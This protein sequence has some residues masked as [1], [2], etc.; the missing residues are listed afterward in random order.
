MRSL[1]LNN[2]ATTRKR[3]VVGFGFVVIW[4][5]AFRDTLAGVV[6]LARNDVGHSHILAIPV[7][8]AFFIYSDRVRIFG[9]G[10]SGEGLQ[11]V[12]SLVLLTGGG[13]LSLL[14]FYT[15]GD[16]VPIDALFLSMASAVLL[17]LGLM[18]CFFPRIDLSEAAFPALL[19][20]LLIPLPTM[21]REGLVAFLVK[22]SSFFTEMLFQ[23]TGTTFYREGTSF[24]LPNVSIEIANECSGIR[25]SIGLFI[26]LLLA[27]HMFLK[28]WWSKTALIVMVIPMVLV[29]NAI[30][31]TTLTLL[32][33]H[34]DKAFLISSPLHRSGGIVFFALALLLVLP[35]LVLLR[36]CE[37][38]FQVE[39]N[40]H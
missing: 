17:L 16:L 20:L 32:A 31:I 27:S 26:S 6:H 28:R 12:I 10:W 8:A 33:V 34:V 36:K 24:L 14:R 11:R 25:S 19:L 5:L 30:R 22:G 18:L 2:R 39:R 38:R 1:V 21:V 4:F 13:I 9:S 23:I 37:R 7:L 3:L 35:V 40:F 29:K 15:G